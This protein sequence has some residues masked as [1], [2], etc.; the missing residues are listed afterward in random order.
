MNRFSLLVI[1]LLAVVTAGSLTFGYQQY[2]RAERLA[3]AAAEPAAESARPAHERVLD[4]VELPA[5]DD[6]PRPSD[7]ADPEPLAAVEPAHPAA[8]RRGAPMRLNELLEDPDF[9]A[10]WQAQQK[11]A[12]DAPYAALFR[13]LHLN[14]QQIDQLK[15]LLAERMTARLDVMNAARE[16][17]LGGR[18]NRAEVNRLLQETHAEID[19]GIRELLGDSGYAQLQQYE[20]TAPERTVVRQLESRLSYSSTPLSTAQAEALVTIL[21]D[22][23]RSTGGRANSAMVFPIGPGGVSGPTAP[24]SNAAIARA[25]GVLSADQLAALRQIQADQQAQRTV[26]EKMREHFNRGRQVT[27]PAPAP[28]G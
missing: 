4:A 21:N 1:L 14:P 24:V 12:L 15:A 28:E 13:Q 19:A 23:S 25:Q 16:Q 22:T 18:E 11:A 9:A 8:T 10:A 3:K 6:T 2:Q 17:G 27:I 26:N 20:R 7:A 5:A